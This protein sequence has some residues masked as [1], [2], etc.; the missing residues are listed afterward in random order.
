MSREYV[1]ERWA[2]PPQLAAELNISL[3][4]VN[5]FLYSEKPVSNPIA[6]LTRTDEDLYIGLMPC[7][8]FGG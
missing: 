1:P 4:A 7:W 3:G 5:S 8:R 6:Y 2:S